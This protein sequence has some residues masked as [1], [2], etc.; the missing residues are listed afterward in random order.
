MAFVLNRTALPA[1]AG[2]D[3][4]C[5]DEFA[6]RAA[7]S[8]SSPVGNRRRT[9]GAFSCGGIFLSSPSE[10]E[11]RSKKYRLHPVREGNFAG[12]SPPADRRPPGGRAAAE[13]IRP[14]RMLDWRGGYQVSVKRI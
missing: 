4:R 14:G 1:V 5:G 3:L 8:F 11:H 2:I 13:R 10:G 7:G 6:I 12:R 9:A